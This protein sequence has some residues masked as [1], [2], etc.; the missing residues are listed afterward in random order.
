MG[1]LLGWY[2]GGYLDVVHR[3]E[4]G[5]LI[6]SEHAVGGSH[7]VLG[8]HQGPPTELPTQAADDGHGPWI[9]VSW[10]NLRPP[11]YPGRFLYAA[12]TR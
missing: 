9:L 6:V 4:G 8:G 3:V 5:Q 11:N 10:S 12:L 1:G 2:P 7:H